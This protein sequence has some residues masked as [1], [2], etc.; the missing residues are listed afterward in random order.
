MQD[1]TLAERTTYRFPAEREAHQDTGFH[2]FAPTGVV[3]FQPVKKQLGKKRPAEE[4]AHNRMGSQ[5]R[6]AAEH[7]LASVKRVRIVTDRFRT[8]KARFADR[9]MRIACGLHNLRQSVRYPAPATAP[10]QVFYF[11]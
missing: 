5:I 1:K 11:R 9:V 4:R 10:E 6:V 7:S 2:A 8:T 3:L